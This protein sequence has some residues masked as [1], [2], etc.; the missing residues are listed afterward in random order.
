[1]DE[2]EINDY[3]TK[4]RRKYDSGKSLYDNGFYSD[5]V[6][7]FF[8][9]MLLTAKAL[10][11]KKDIETRKQKGI[12]NEFYENYVLKENFDQTSYKNFARTQSLRQEVD[13]EARDTI[14]KITAKQKMKHCI[15]FL[16][17]CEKYF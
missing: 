8:Y 5:S 6:T 3:R 17:E 10:L 12:L 16:N 9:A 1:M 2:Q 15:D 14:T 7:Q 4:A 13:Y 11:L